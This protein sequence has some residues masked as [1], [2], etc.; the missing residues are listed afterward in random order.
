ML[1]VQTTDHVAVLT[2]N[3]PEKLNAL[4]GELRGAML[5]AVASVQSDDDVRAVIFA[6]AGRAFC[7]SA[8]LTSGGS[9]ATAPPTQHD[10]L[11]DLGFGRQAIAVYGLDKPV[12]AAV[13]GVSTGA[14]KSL[15]L[16]CDVRVGSDISRKAQAELHRY[17]IT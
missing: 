3:R 16:A 12:I 9:G 15:A 1:L 2:L 17:L 4:D 5:D 10:R 6:G 7:S 13:N 11:D 14:G 8:D